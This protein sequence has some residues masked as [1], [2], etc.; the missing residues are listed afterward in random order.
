MS[1]EGAIQG[2]G[3]TFLGQASLFW[4]LDIS[5]AQTAQ[6]QECGPE[7]GVHFLKRPQTSLTNFQKGLEEGTAG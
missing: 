3:S 2:L 1:C 7:V 6:A 4:L 5:T